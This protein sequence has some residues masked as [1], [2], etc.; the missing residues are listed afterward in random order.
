MIREVE[1]SGTSGRRYLRSLNSQE[2]YKT[3]DESVI[4]AQMSW[5]RKIHQICQN[6]Q[7]R[8]FDRRHRIICD[9]VNIDDPVNGHFELEII[10][11]GVVSVV[12]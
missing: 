7:Y 11:E 5:A 3:Y 2:Y 8:I 12:N 10:L 9:P 1:I 4:M 6:R